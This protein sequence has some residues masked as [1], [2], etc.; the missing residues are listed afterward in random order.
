MVQQFVVKAEH[1]LRAA[2]VLAREGG[3]ADVACAALADFGVAPRYPG[4]EDE[5]GVVD[6]EDALRM[7]TLGADLIR[8]LTRNSRL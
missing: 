5:V 3:L 1:D 7:A 8:P 6:S 4:W 2:A